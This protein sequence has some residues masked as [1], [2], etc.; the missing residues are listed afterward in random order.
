MGSGRA[1]YGMLTI[2]SRA[3]T[4]MTPFSFCRTSPYSI[5]DRDGADG[6]SVT[7]LLTNP[8]AHCLYTVLVL[9]HRADADKDIGWNVTGYPSLSA[10]RQD[11][12]ETRLD[13]YLYRPTLPVE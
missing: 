4:W 9:T 7:Y 13:C 12:K 11:R 2:T 10:K 5:V 6:L 8:S 1:C 3:I